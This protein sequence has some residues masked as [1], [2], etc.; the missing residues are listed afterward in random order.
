MFTV[1]F[2]IDTKNY[3]T[4]ATSIIA[5]PT[6]IKLSNWTLTMYTSVMNFFVLYF[7]IGGFLLN[8]LIG[9]LTG[10]ILANNSID[11]MLH[12][13]YFV[14]AHFHYV[15]SLS[16]VYIV[17]AAFYNYVALFNMH[18]NYTIA[19][20]TYVIFLISS[21]LLFMPLHVLGLLG[22]PRRVLDFNIYLSHFSS[23]NM[24]GT[25]GIITA[26]ILLP[27]SIYHNDIRG[28]HALVA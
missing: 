5:V 4:T 19:H 11:I 9:G 27:F 16:V 3:F 21:H 18:I 23:F 1:G 14:I 20:I 6:L 13:T 24:L 10:L 28:T 2:D 12:D 26:F 25:I 17:I 7:Y 8:F 15:L 22:L